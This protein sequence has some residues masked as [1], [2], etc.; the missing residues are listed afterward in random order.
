MLQNTTVGCVIV[1]KV[2]LLSVCILFILHMCMIICTS[3]KDHVMM[4]REQWWWIKCHYEKYK[5]FTVFLIKVLNMFPLPRW[6]CLMY[7]CV[8]S[9]THTCRGGFIWKQYPG[10]ICVWV[11][12]CFFFFTKNIWQNWTFSTIS[13][14]RHIS[15]K[16]KQQGLK[17]CGGYRLCACLCV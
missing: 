8:S 14:Q 12:V 2:Q 10:T 4:T 6:L 1:L 3:V 9:N 15:H 11:W 5:T 17:S 16:T 7:L 13:S